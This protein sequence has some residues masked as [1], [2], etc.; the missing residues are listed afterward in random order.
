MLIQQFR[1]TSRH[2]TR[3]CWQHQFI[4]K[5]CTYRLVLAIGVVQLHLRFLIMLQVSA[6][7]V[8]REFDK[9]LRATPVVFEVVS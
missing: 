2:F 6:S 8:S 3:P 9:N 5:V 4:A 7:C 1:Q